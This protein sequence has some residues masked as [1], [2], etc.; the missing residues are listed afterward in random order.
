MPQ[1]LT[2]G[3][4]LLLRTA[5]DVSLS[6]ARSS[7]S[8]FNLYGRCQPQPATTLFDHLSANCYRLVPRSTS[9]I[10]GQAGLASG[11]ATTR[12]DDST[13]GCDLLE[14]CQRP[15]LPCECFVL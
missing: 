11:V 6:C 13:F 2:I 5:K 8:T 12:A 1:R 7:Q 9:S 3:A 4:E 14:T 15:E 10:A